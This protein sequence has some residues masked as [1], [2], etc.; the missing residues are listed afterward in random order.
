MMKKGRLASGFARGC[1]QTL[2]LRFGA[3]S[4][5]HSTAFAPP[6]EGF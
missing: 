2:V 5:F 6:Q 1:G 4:T 3:V